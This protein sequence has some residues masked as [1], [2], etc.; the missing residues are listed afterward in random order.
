[1]SGYAEFRM[2]PPTL[3]D[4]LSHIRSAICP[5]ALYP[6]K[7]GRS[8]SMPSML[9]SPSSVLISLSPSPSVQSAKFFSVNT[10]RA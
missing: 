7:I 8:A 10:T 2:R 6:M 4:H 3:S 5:P 1:M 9:Q